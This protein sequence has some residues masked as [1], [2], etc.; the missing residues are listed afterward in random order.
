MSSEAEMPD[1][2]LLEV[3]A[4]ALATDETKV[5]EYRVA[6]AYQVIG[7]MQEAEFVVLVPGTRDEHRSDSRLRGLAPPLPRSNH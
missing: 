5:S 4:R 1:P 3:I 6:Q 2:V 7:A